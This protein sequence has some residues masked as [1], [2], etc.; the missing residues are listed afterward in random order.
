MTGWFG[1][2]LTA[3]MVVGLWFVV[4]TGAEEIR[5]DLGETF[6]FSSVPMRVISLAPSNTEMLFAL[7]VGNRIV[8]VTEYCNY[9]LE[10]NSINKV[11]GFNTVNLE[12]V[13][14][15]RPE[16][17]LAIRGNDMESLRSLRQLGIPVFSFDIQ[18]L[19]QVSSAL[20]RLGALLG[21]E[22]RANTIADSLESRV[23]LVRREIK[24]VP[25]KPKV[26]WGFWGDPIYTAGAK[27]MI[28][29]VIETA[30]GKNMG[31]LAKGA[32]PQ[33][34]LETVV[35]WAPDVIITTHVPGGVGHLL[36]E[37]NRL[38][39][40]DGWKLIPAVQSGR[41]HYVEADWL[42]R[43]GPRLVDALQSVAHLLHEKD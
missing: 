40:T 23:R 3:I 31:R 6:S 5:D 36:N 11:A 29:D 12:K 27:T 39:E 17:I 2:S 7:G 32:W 21:V 20:R 22:N 33:I 16:L 18:N 34:S 43:P 38:R 26:M 19:D 35:Q 4:P 24:D 1:G 14:Q 28:D 10:A 9:P 25:D 15:V 8:G 37:V 30:G 42:L 41:I 13:A